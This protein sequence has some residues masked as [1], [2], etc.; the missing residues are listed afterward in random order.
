MKRIVL[1]MVMSAGWI[2]GAQAGMVSVGFNDFD[3][4]PQL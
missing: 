3:A 1:A 4:S 2:G